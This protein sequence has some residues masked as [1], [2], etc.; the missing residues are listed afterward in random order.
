M[1]A[2]SPAFS[3]ALQRSH[4]VAG[5]VVVAGVTLQ[6]EPSASSVTIDRTNAQRR[7][8]TL[9]LRDPTGSLTFDEASDLLHPLSGNEFTVARGIQYDTGVTAN[10]PNGAPPLAGDIE[11]IPQGTFGINT[12]TIQDA[13]T[14]DL[15]ISLTGADRSYQ[16]SAAKLINTYPIANNSNLASTVQALITA[17]VPGT[18]F[19]FTDTG[20]VIPTIALQPGADPWQEALT[21]VAAAGCLLYYDVNGICTLIPY[22]DPTT[23]PVTWTYSEGANCTVQA[24]TKTLTRV[25]VFSHVVCDGT[26]SKI[27]PPIRGEWMDDNPRSPT[28]WKGPYGDVVNYLSSSLYVSQAQAQPAATA[29]GLAGLGSSESVAIT[30][31]PNPGHEALDV[32]QINR[33]RLQMEDFYVVDAITLPMRY[34]TGAQLAGRRIA[35][36]V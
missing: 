1:Y 36:Q 16:V 23:A 21:L 32:I 31:T 25:G 7:A 10:G 14:G 18:T 33:S 15:K 35:R 19:A 2:V 8:C 3:Q 5:S 6:I 17:R 24:G 22:P 13:A 30:A 27:V 34:A 9:D 11:L 28:Y 29:I 12:S 26:G 4:R 20:A